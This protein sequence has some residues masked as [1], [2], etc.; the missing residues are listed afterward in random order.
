MIGHDTFGR[1][2]FAYE[3][4]ENSPSAAVQHWLNTLCS[5]NVDAIVSLYAPEAVLLG[6]LA[7]KIAQGHAEIK[8][9]FEMFVKQKPCGKIT[10]MIVQNFGNV[11]I[12]DGTY[13]FELH[14]GK[15]TT[16]VEARYTFVFQYRQGAWVIMT[17]HSS[18]QP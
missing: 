16:K 9:Y 6:T 1:N 7:E 8:T 14:N 18:K 12:V 17:H 2:S 4:Y 10:S 3:S 13:T 15:R 5:H 11:K